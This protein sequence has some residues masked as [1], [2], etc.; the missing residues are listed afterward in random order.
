MDDTPEDKQY[1]DAMVLLYSAMG[2]SAKG[3]YD[4]AI[5]RYGIALTVLE[6]LQGSDKA[7][8]FS[9]DKMYPTLL[10]LRADA[11][12]GK[13]DYER[14]LA[15]YDGSIARMPDHVRAYTGRADLYERMGDRSRAIADFQ[16]ALDLNPNMLP[17]YVEECK[18][19]LKR[20]G[21]MH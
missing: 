19:A 9:S 18:Q 15:D 16:K 14:A 6:E 5:L 20:L 4:E 12:K 17:Q 11:Y 10:A 7:G 21:T 8:R 2:L 1:L 13:G 3:D